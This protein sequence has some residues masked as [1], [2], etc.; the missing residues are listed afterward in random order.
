[1]KT[2][3][4]VGVSLGSG[5]CSIGSEQNCYHAPLIADPPPLMKPTVANDEKCL[6]WNLSTVQVVP[7]TVKALKVPSKARSQYEKAC[8][9][10]QRKK[11]EEAEQ[12]LRGAI[13]RFQ[14]YSAA[15]VMLGIVLDEQHKEQEAREACSYAGAV[16]AKYLPAYLCSAEFSA[17][18]REWEQLLNLANASLSLNSGDNGYGYYYQAMA[19]LNQKNLPDARKSALHAAEIDANHTYV[20]LYFLLA[21]IYETDGDR[22][23]A[24]T[25]L[26]QALK[27]AS[28]Q[29]QE[30]AAMQYLAELEAKPSAGNVPKAGTPGTSAGRE[31][32]VEVPTGGT[33]ASN[34]ELETP[35]E[36]WAPADVDYDDLPVASG[37]SCPQQKVLDGA[38]RRIL[39]LVQN[40]DRFTATETLIHQ[41][42]DHSGHLGR[43]ITAQFNYMVSYSPTEDGY[44]A[45]DEFRNGSLSQAGFPDNIATRGT[46]SLILIFHP[47]NIVNFKME[48][49]GLGHWH[50]EP[51]WRVRFEQLDGRPNLTSAIAVGGK[52]YGVKLR[53]KAWI[54]ADSY[55]VARLETDMQESIPKI[56]LLLDHLSIEYRPIKS[57]ID[58]E[59]L[60]LPSSAELYMDFLGR[61]FYRKH[62]FANYKIFSVESQYQIADP[63]N[64]ANAP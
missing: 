12:Y 58:K 60:W 17:R 27:H 43:P 46:P 41:P 37:V 8:S 1:M 21:Q 22:T 52:S 61:R 33:V 47:K 55:Q 50:G 11:Y 13:S 25:Y 51:A 29:E 53:G 48:C 3:P 20:P 40:V 6:P 54:L 44:L 42:V 64:A 7:V 31:T 32:S 2:R 49:E 16:N 4:D 59:Q 26:R 63:K 38:S 14:N 10:F 18:N 15:W 34:A 24:A 45:V 28:N 23:T 19:Y 62:A 5:G 57:P 9:A 36:S 56:H 39:E 35:D 30:R